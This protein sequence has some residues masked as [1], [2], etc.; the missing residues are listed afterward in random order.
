DSGPGRGPR[1]WQPASR[2]ASGRAARGRLVVRLQ[3]RDERV[4]GA[5]HVPVVLE[6]LVDDLLGQLDS[7][8][9][10]LGTQLLDDRGAL[11]GQLL[12]APRDDPCGLL[13][14]SGAQLLDG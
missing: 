4:D 5:P 2:R 13:L 8:R 6:L 1:G 12:L 9:A 14:G 7:Q 10:D 11:T 3:A